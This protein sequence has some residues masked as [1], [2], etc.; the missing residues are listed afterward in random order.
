LAYLKQFNISKYYIEHL[1]GDHVLEDVKL[2][3]ERFMSDSLVINNSQSVIIQFGTAHNFAINNSKTINIT[4][5]NTKNSTTIQGKNVELTNCTLQSPNIE[6]H[7]LHLDNVTINDN[8]L[9]RVTGKLVINKCTFN[10]SV[11][12]VIKSCGAK[13]VEWEIL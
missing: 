2:N 9:L 10:D 8:L 12:E 5:L 1:T 13:K 11:I 7:D 4:G 6:A 3:L